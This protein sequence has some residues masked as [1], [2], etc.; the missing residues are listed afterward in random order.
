MAD[1]E[2]PQRPV[3]VPDPISE[4]YWSAIDRGEL[5][6]QRCTRCRVFQHPPAGI[7]AACLSSELAFEPVSGRGS[8]KTFTVT[9]G[10]AR[11]PAFEAR[12]P[13]ALAIVELKE[14]PRLFMMCNPTGIDPYRLAIGQPVEVEFEEIAPGRLIP[15]FRVVASSSETSE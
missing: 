8:I 3:P 12:Q 13:Y 9:T 14:Q 5:V 15:Q 6:I 1:A 7:C 10:G 4:P 2:I 11:H